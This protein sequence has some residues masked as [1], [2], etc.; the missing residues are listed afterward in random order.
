M[1]VR[2]II[3]REERGNLHTIVKAKIKR[4][5]SARLT[6]HDQAVR[7]LDIPRLQLVKTHKPTTIIFNHFYSSFNHIKVFNIVGLQPI[8]GTQVLANII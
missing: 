7:L 2:G 6:S 5:H 4:L 8:L 1:V 3:K